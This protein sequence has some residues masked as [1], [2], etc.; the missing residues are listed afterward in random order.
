MKNNNHLDLSRLK[1][2]DVVT[3]ESEIV[4]KHEAVSYSR[5]EPRPNTTVSYIN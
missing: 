1:K 2:V 3:V 4:D 5:T